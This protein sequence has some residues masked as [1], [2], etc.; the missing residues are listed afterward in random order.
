[1]LTVET[2]DC[3]GIYLQGWATAMGFL[4]SCVIFVCVIIKHFFND[5]QQSK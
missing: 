1:M 3:E 2:R 5:Q 4:N